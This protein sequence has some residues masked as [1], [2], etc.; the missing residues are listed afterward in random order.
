MVGA[1]TSSPSEMGWADDALE[2]RIEVDEDGLARLVHLAACAAGRAAPTEG[3]GEGPTTRDRRAA[4]LPLVDV[5]MSGSGRAWSGGR[6]AESVVGGRLRYVGHE[7][8]VNDPWRELQIDLEDASHGAQSRRR[9]PRAQGT[10]RPP[11]P[12]P[13]HKRWCGSGDH[14]VG[15]LLSRLWAG[16]SGGSVGRC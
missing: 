16:R 4:G 6:Y 5:V 11:V 3:N 13:P 7:E 2:L 10:G 12:G 1:R 14:R 15:D 9:L 8:R